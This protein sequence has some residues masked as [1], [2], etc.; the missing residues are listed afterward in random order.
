MFLD[1]SLYNTTLN[2]QA[3]ISEYRWPYTGRV[4]A[5]DVAFMRDFQANLRSRLPSGSN[6]TIEL[7]FNARVCC[8]LPPTPPPPSTHTPCAYL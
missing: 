3:L 5:P 7:A 8:I 4:N 1:T 6:F 2:R